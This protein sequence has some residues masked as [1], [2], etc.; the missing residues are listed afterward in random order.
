MAPLEWFLPVQVLVTLGLW[1]GALW[2]LPEC[3]RGTYKDPIAGSC[4]EC[5]SLCD[6]AEEQKTEPCVPPTV[7][8][9]TGPGVI[10]APTSASVSTPVVA[11]QCCAHR[12]QKH[13][14]A[15]NIADQTSAPV[16]PR[17]IKD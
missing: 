1:V 10:P 13:R 4:R 15:G 9:T 16:S 3:A 14:N 17:L 7:T 5:S 8:I 2:A 6:R 12:N 11:A